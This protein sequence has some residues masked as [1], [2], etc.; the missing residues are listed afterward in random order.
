MKP[1]ENQVVIITSTLYDLDTDVGKV[2]SKLLLKT[3]KEANKR[4][5]AMIIAD[6]GS[7]SSF[8]EKLKDYNIRVV[9]PIKGMG[10]QRR[11]AISLAMETE[12]EVMHG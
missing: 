7:S 5:Y 2:R 9:S 3:I 11:M 1:I 10:V 8:L 12:K 4:S 6:G